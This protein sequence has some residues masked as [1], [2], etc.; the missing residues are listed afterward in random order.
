MALPV[1]FSQALAAASAT[2][3]AASQSPAAGV[4]TL[5]GSA[6]TGGVAVLDAQRRVIV[7]SGSDDTGITFTVKGTNG[8]GSQIQE[9]IAGAS[10]AAAAT[11]LDFKTV[12]SVTHT[13]SV[14]VP[15]PSARTVSVRASGKSSTGTLHRSASASRSSSAPGRSITPSSTPTTTR[16]ISSPGFPI[17]WP[18]MMR[19]LLPRRPPLLD[20]PLFRSQRSAY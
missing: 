8:A 1:I 3:I 20:R 5:N 13:G 2:N 11:N 10:G 18:S 6:V 9:T 15:S 17:R 4:I 12:T 16:T 19:P 7:T 14:A